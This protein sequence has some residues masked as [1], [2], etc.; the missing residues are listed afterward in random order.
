MKTLIAKTTKPFGYSFNI[1]S[2]HATGSNPKD[3]PSH[4][5]SLS[6]QDFVIQASSTLKG[7]MQSKVTLDINHI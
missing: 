1:I 6:Y 5:V 3:P 2:S 7:D 4:K